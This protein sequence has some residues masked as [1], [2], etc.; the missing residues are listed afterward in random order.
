MSNSTFFSGKVQKL[1][2]PFV[3]L[4]PPADAPHLK[5]LPLA[6]GELAQFHDGEEGARYI[7]YIEL[8]TGAIRGNHYHKI[9]NEWTYVISGR[10]QLL[11]ED[12]TTHERASLTMQSGDLAFVAPGVAHALRT[13]EP[14]GAVEF[15][16]LQ[17]NAG[18]IYPFRLEE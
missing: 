3:S 14:G 11:L 13:L 8:L 7:A 2:L 18:D 15:S 12:I 10:L 1:S 16:P 6:Q 4:P 5:R 17:F 9:K